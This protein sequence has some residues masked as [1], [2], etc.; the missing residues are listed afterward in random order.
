MLEYSLKELP[1]PMELETKR[2]LKSTLAANR[3]LAELKGVSESLPN[4]NIIINTLAL[5]EAKDS[6]E[7]ENIV[8]TYDEM[9]KAELYSTLVISS[10]TKE[11]QNYAQALRTGFSLVQKS[12]LLSCN[13]IIAIQ[14]LLEGNNAGFR[15]LPGTDLKNISTGKTIYTPPQDNQTIVRLM[16]NLECYINDASLSDVDPLIKLAIIHH[17]FES[18]HPFYDGNGRTGRIINILYLVLEGLLDIPILYLSR[19]FIE[20]K[21]DY[22]RLLQLVRDTNNWEE[23]II[24]TLKGIETTSKQTIQMIEKIKNLMQK[25]KH[26][27]RKNFRFYSQDLLNNIFCNPYTKIE[28]L[29]RDLQISRL[30]ATKYLD[31]LADAGYLEKHKIWRSNYYINR[32]LF[33]LLCNPP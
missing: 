9:Y 25:Y 5:Q 20:T 15:K 11:V 12:K 2:V 17:Q 4:Q 18:I 19:Y 29:E 14:Q 13:H 10:A 16:R 7:I 31:Q 27:I 21:A 33:D 24:Y 1:L 8:T 22:Y 3:Y 23:W 32:P 26:D 28:Y 30:T 6:S